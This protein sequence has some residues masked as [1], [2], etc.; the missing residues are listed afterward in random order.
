MCYGAANEYPLMS[1]LEYPFLVIQ[2]VILLAIILYYSDLLS[3]SS[4]GAFVAY[5]SVIYACL[6]GM[7]P[8][9]V[10]ITL[11]VSIISNVYHVTN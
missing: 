8:L 7:V 4:L 3:I 6:T 1:Y 5:S 10:M 9:S 2:D 11:M